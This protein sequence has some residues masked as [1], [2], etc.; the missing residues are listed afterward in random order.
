[1]TMTVEKKVPQQIQDAVEMLNNPWDYESLK[2]SR[3][4]S[5]QL[6]DD[7][8]NR[9]RA[10]AEWLP[11]K[12]QW[13]LYV[14]WDD[15]KP[16]H[17]RNV[18]HKVISECALQDFIATGCSS[19]RDREAEDKQKFPGSSVQIQVSYLK[20]VPTGKEMSYACSDCGDTTGKHN[21]DINLSVEI[22]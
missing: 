14:E 6:Q 19:N 15:S 10:E 2:Y 12:Q 5:R 9:I 18:V 13:C 16:L 1:M 22:Q 4:D 21:Q 11:F 8:K 3:G 7:P 20:V 17:A